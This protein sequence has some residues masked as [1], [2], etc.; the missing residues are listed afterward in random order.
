MNESVSKECGE[1]ADRLSD[2]LDGTADDRLYEHISSCDTCRDARHEAE[3]ALAIARDAGADYREPKDL[4]A[5]LGRAIENDAE[6]PSEAVPKKAAPLTP[7]KPGLPSARKLRWAAAA[8]LAA[9]A[10]ILAIRSGGGGGENEPRASA[11]WRGIVERVAVASGGEGLE[12]C[13]ARGENCRKLAAGGEF[14][15]S[16]LLRTDGRT[17]ARIRLSDGTIVTLERST[18]LELLA[19]GARRA[20][21]VR[22]ALTADVT[23]AT[24]EARIELPR[25]AIAVHGTKFALRAEDASASVD[26][27]RG[28]VTLS[29]AARRS[30]RVN[31]GESA[32]LVDGAPP[33]VSFSESFGE[34]LAWSDETFG[35]AE[36][37][38]GPRGLGELKAK[39]PGQDAELA[40]AVTLATHSVRVRISGAVARTEIEEVFENHTDQVLEG[41]YRFP[42]P[43][44]AQIERLALEVVGKLEEGAFLDRERAAG[45]WRG[46]IVNAAPK[47]KRPLDEIVWV[48]GPWKDPA[49]LEWQRGGRFELPT[50]R[51]APSWRCATLW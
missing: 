29:D 8:V 38:S 37:T 15:K 13:V 10:G 4:E 16:A 34:S 44:D 2:V 20:R 40:G 7:A 41:I 22:G 46:A 9:A 31:A 32:R 49:L 21:L 6:A 12:L 25:G 42:M 45:I 28:S 18:E 14:P 5:R 11:A 26:V 23:R 30:V 24:D 27:A 43:P 17:R 50:T 47:T 33:F 39:K 3:R 36:P 48:P 19:D 1:V 51:P 35:E